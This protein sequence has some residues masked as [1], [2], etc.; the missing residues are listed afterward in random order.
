MYLCLVIH[1]KMIRVKDLGIR[2]GD[3]WILQN[4]SFEIP[5]GAK[6]AIRGES[7]SGKTS[8]LNALLG[9]VPP[10]AG[11]VYFDQTP[12]SPSTVD[13]IRRQTAYVPQELGFTVFPNLKTLFWRPFEFKANAGKKPSEE[14][15]REVFARFQLD[16]KLL[17]RPVKEVSGGQK[18][19]ILLALAVLL[20]KPYIFLDEPTS[21]LDKDNKNRVAD[22]FFSL[23][24]TVIA[25]THDET[26]I[27]RSTM[28]IDLDQ[29]KK[30][31]RS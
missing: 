9:F 7:G 11:Q 28:V 22:Y 31:I 13:Q 23:R 14:K 8:L 30:H 12:L 26:W 2:Y 18:Q 29:I 24:D 21:A 1:F 16:Y 17:N 15:I 20:D 6:V 25:V 5:D 27:E 19:R 10:A 4:L 3:Q